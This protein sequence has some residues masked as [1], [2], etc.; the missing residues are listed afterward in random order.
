VSILWEAERIF[1]KTT[2][3]GVH[4]NRR[5]AAPRRAVEQWMST[6]SISFHSSTVG[7]EDN[8]VANTHRAASL[9]LQS[10]TII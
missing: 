4:I 7:V 5:L 6:Q 2:T 10:C 8:L 1:D 3:T 9:S